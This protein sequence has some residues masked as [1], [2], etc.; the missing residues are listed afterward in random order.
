MI[1][2]AVKLRALAGSF[3]YKQ[4]C[5]FQNF[6]FTVY[7][8]WQDFIVLWAGHFSFL[9]RLSKTNTQFNEKLSEG[10]EIWHGLNCG[11]PLLG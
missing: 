11:A 6:S 10:S 1:I 8:G 3:A 9:V 5:N 7:G 2:F 4:H